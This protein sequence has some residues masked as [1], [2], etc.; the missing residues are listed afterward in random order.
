MVALFH[1]SAD[2]VSQPEL[3]STRAHLGL[4]LLAM[5]LL[6][7]AFPSP[8]WW[9]L[10]HVALVPITLLAAWAHHWKRLFW[11][12][13]AASY[14]WWLIMLGWLIGVTG[15]GYAALAAYMALYI[16][17]FLLL[18]RLLDRRFHWPAVIT[19][20][21]VFVSLEFIRGTFLQGGMAWFG[22]GHSQAPYR[23]GQSTNWLIQVADIAGDWTVSFVV[24]MTNGFVVDLIRH[25]L[26]S[27]NRGRLRVVSFSA[28][29]WGLTLIAA[30][31]YGKA[32]CDADLGE[33]R[34]VIVAVIQTNISQ[35]NKQSQTKEIMLDNWARLIELTNKA[36][37]SDPKPQIIVWPE[38][39]VPI[40]LNREMLAVYRR[41][42]DRPDRDKDDID[43]YGFHEQIAALAAEHR[44]DMFVG[45]GS[46]LGNPARRFNS[47][48][49]YLPDGAQA[50]LSYS[51]IDRVPFGEYIPWVEDWPWLKNLFLKYL[52]PLGPGNDYTLTPGDQR[53]VFSVAR[54]TGEPLQVT[55]PICFEDA[56]ARSTLALCYGR[57]GKRSDLMLNL[58]NDGW[59]PGTDQGLQHVQMAVLRSIETRVP[60]ARSV[61]TGVSVFIDSCGRVGPFVTG[62][63]GEIQQIDGFAVDRVRIDPRSSLFGRVG[64]T[65]VLALTFTTGTLAA[66]A[67]V[68]RKRSY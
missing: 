29:I 57:A 28:A 32:R 25:L 47:A 10:A 49:H 37:R 14:L 5:L 43:W 23:P 65:P 27:R 4:S 16:P 61:N 51:K 62:K 59:Y 44:V 46:R 33:P 35:D 7:L 45:A 56:F 67:F 3:R 64:T 20:P 15:G 58:T 52:S 40:E 6:G 12:S 53:T 21:M 8:G 22:L 54:E 19:V 18:W 11:T 39:M 30:L 1:S 66:L 42:R 26:G 9:P 36:L 38:T 34:S 31:L 60:M 13:F 41:F 55:V 50:D 17:A 2:R 68:T 48:F 63:S 24:A